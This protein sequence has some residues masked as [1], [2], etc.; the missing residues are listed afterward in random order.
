M[1]EPPP[2]GLEREARS[3]A[4]EAIT[5][6]RQPLQRPHQLGPRLDEL[7][8]EARWRTRPAPSGLPY[9][10]DAP[11][12]PWSGRS[13]VNHLERELVSQ[14]QREGAWEEE[15]L[16]LPFPDRPIPRPVRSSDGQDRSRQ[17]HGFGGCAS[18]S[19]KNKRGFQHRLPFA[20]RERVECSLFLPTSTL[21]RVAYLHGLCRSVSL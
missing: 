3:G 17:L 9:L 7:E 6:G 20:S 12:A 10:D 21:R 11:A 15:A 16:R 5:R 8:C 19:P 2:G 4:P 1:S 14:R 13:G 18:G